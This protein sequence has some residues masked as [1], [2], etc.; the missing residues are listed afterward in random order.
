MGAGTNG[1]TGN[2]VET[3]RSHTHRAAVTMAPFGEPRWEG[4]PT[5]R[6]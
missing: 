2:P 4:F 1:M 6:K 3:T 5:R